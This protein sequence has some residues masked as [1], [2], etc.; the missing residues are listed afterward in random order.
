MSG[1]SEFLMV[2]IS[3]KHP[4]KS[5]EGGKEIAEEKERNLFLPAPRTRSTSEE[6]VPDESCVVVRR[7]QMKL[8]IEMSVELV[9]SEKRLQ[10][11]NI[12]PDASLLGCYQ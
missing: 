11:E 5:S 2:F 12:F 10:N 1:K 3:A 9:R 6:F 7:G 8:K 4:Q